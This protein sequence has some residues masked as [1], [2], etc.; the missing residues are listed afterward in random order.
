MRSSRLTLAAQNALLKLGYVV[1]PNG[2]A[3]PDTL[4]ALRDLE[5]S[6]GLPASTEITARLVK[7]LTSALN[8]QAAR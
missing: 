3:G 8:A 1:K 2:V 6:H 4:S 7:T 5:K